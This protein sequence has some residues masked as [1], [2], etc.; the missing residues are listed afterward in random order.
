MPKSPGERV[1]Y[2][3]EIAGYEIKV[4][5]LR[6]KLYLVQYGEQRVPF[7]D[8]KEAAHELG[9]CIFHALQCEGKLHEDD[10]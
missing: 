3:T 8:Y 10:Q 7:L 1:C 4:T 9:E 2:K 6:N 5:K